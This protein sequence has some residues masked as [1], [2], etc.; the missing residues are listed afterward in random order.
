MSIDRE[1][2]KDVVHIYNEI[3]LSHKI[4]WNDVI[5]S[6]MDGIRDYHT[7]WNKSDRE[8]QIYDT[9]DMWNLKNWYKWTYLQNRN[10]L[11]D[12]ENKFMVTERGRGRDKLGIWG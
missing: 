7:K 12:T 4:V 2:D 6:N 9:S 11:T 5:F 1:M 10:R 8:R 3:L